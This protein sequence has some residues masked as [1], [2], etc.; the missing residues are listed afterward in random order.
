[1]PLGL[2]GVAIFIGWANDLGHKPSDLLKHADNGVGINMREQ[3][4]VENLVESRNVGQR[5]CDVGNGSAIV[6]HALHSASNWRVGL[7]EVKGFES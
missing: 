3:F 2:Y 6:S 7:K 5:V 1:M 4:L